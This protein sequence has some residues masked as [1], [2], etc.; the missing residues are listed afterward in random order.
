MT[1]GTTYEIYNIYIEKFHS[2]LVYVGLR[3]APIYITHFLHSN[4]NPIQCKI[5]PLFPGFLYPLLV[6]C[7]W[8]EGL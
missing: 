5:L 7:L 1:Y 3:L 2:K 4:W 6:K 8:L